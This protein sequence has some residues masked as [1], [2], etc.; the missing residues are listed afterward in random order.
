MKKLLIIGTVLI[1]ISGE[2]LSMGHPHNLFAAR[3][4]MRVKSSATVR[5]KPDLLEACSWQPTIC[6]DKATFS[7]RLL[8]AL[9]ESSPINS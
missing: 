4:A 9:A 1:G 3:K 2:A 8:A 7:K 5:K 6:V